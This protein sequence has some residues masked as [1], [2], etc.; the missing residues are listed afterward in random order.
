MKKNRIYTLIVAVFLVINVVLITNYKNKRN[1]SDDA[2]RS[3]GQIISYANQG[4]SFDTPAPDFTMRTI[5]GEN[6]TLSNWRGK[7][8]IL[9]FTRFYLSE[10]PMLLYLDHLSRK[11]GDKAILFFVNSLG[12]HDVNATRE[13]MSFSSPIIED[14]GTIAALFNARPTETIIVGKD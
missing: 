10:L 12:K 4:L 2:I 5:E 1:K 9:K 13:F 8:I 3:K 11:F 14:N 6:I 7:V